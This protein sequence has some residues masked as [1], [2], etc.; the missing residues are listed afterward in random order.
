MSSCIHANVCLA[1]M[2][3]TN[4][5]A[6]LSKHCP[7]CAYFDPERDANKMHIMVDEHHTYYNEEHDRYITKRR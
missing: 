3:V 2:N 4:S 5:I 6:P 7:I 1:W